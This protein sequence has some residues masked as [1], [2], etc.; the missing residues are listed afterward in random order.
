MPMSSPTFRAELIQVT[1]LT[2]D[3]REFVFRPA[4][5]HGLHFTAGQSVDIF[6]APKPVDHPALTRAYSICSPPEHAHALTVVANLVP[7]GKGTPYLF[8][9][10]VGTTV[11]M[12]GPHGHFVVDARGNRDY[13]FVATGT[14][15]APLL[16][17]IRHLLT[18]GTTRRMTLYWGLRGQRDLYYQAVLQA[19]AHA[20]ANFSFVTTL[21][22]PEAGW[23]GA[24]GRVTSL[25][26]RTIGSVA[27]LD[28]YVCGSQEMIQDVRGVLRTKGLCPVHTE[29]FY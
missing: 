21:S 5:T 15:I 26:E 19:L 22:Q 24:C 9:F 28:V 16:S 2:H 20:H 7:G 8:A 6:L 27:T 11:A 1:P 25:I 3:V 10:G 12:R 17:M 4:M 23:T 29:K 18:V 13:L 14:G